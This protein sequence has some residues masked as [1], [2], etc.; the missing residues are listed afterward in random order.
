MGTKL[1]GEQFPLCFMPNTLSWLLFPVWNSTD[2]N[3]T[4]L[5]L[6]QELHEFL[7]DLQDWER[8]MKDKDRKLKS[9]AYKDEQTIR[10]ARNRT[11][12]FSIGQGAKV[13]NPK[14]NCH[15]VG[16]AAIPLS[17]TTTLLS[18]ESTGSDQVGLRVEKTPKTEAEVLLALEYLHMLGVVYRDLKP[19]YVLV[20]EDGHIM[21]SDFDLS[22]RCAVSPTLVISS[23]ACGQFSVLEIPWYQRWYQSRDPATV[24]GGRMSGSSGTSKGN[25]EQE[26]LIKEALEENLR[27][28]HQSLQEVGRALMEVLT[29]IQQLNICQQREGLQWEGNIDRMVRRENNPEEEGFEIHCRIDEE[30]L[31]GP[32]MWK[33]RGIMMGIILIL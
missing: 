9:Q 27:P 16:F 5:E 10:I 31:W 19:E 32:E 33:E 25:S 4:W 12:V 17:K 24:S 29:V 22:L 28:V 6:F 8:S 3:L 26:A 13:E 15:I 30:K 23:P 20:R 18:P 2:C 11:M 14:Q 1:R 7:N 21:L